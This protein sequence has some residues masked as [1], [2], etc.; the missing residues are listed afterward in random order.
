MVT[1]KQF[2]YSLRPEISDA[3]LTQHLI[4]DGGSTILNLYTAEL[5][6]TTAPSFIKKITE[7]WAY[8]VKSWDQL[9]SAAWHNDLERHMSFF[10]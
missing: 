5:K 4:P 10:L 6:I 8:V 2:Y 3:V 1:N 9:C 7:A